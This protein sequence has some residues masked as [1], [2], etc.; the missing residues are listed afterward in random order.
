ML[1]AKHGVLGFALTEGKDFLAFVSAGTPVSVVS[2]RQKLV[3]KREF[4]ESLTLRSQGLSMSYES[5][6]DPVH[7][8]LAA[9]SIRVDVSR[10]SDRKH[11]MSRP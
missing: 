10:G 7:S 5:M 3:C 8:A 1:T 11:D 4:L 6:A 2:C 9:C